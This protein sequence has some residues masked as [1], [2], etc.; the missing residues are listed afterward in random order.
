LVLEEMMTVTLKNWLEWQDSGLAYILPDYIPSIDQ[1]AALYRQTTTAIHS[2]LATVIDSHLSLREIAIKQRQDL[3]LLTR[4]LIPHLKRQI[5]SLH[6]IVADLPKPTINLTEPIEPSLP[7][8]THGVVAYVDD[9]ACANQHMSKIITDIGYEFIGIEDAAN[10]LELL[11]DKQPDLI[12]MESAMS[13]TNGRH[14]CQQMR[15]A[16]N[17]ARVPVVLIVDRENLA[18][19]I[20][21]KLAGA[22]RIVTHP[23]DQIKISELIQSYLGLI[24]QIQSVSG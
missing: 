9:N 21:A 22:N 15:R 4:S 13:L 12:I 19:R 24:P 18:E 7:I 10:T 14:I 6:P 16:T 20:L 23:L 11:A 2:N 3:L 17:L 8:V 1:S 5:I